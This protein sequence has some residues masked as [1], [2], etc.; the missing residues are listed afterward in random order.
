MTT[1]LLRRIRFGLPGLPTRGWAGRMLRWLHTTLG[2]TVG[3][4]F[5][6]IMYKF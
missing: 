6:W 4:S 2:V 3:L 5:L 1:M